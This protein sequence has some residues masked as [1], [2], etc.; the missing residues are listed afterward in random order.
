MRLYLDE[1]S[2]SS[3]LA[4]L[5]RAAGHDIVTCPELGSEGASDVVQFSQSNRDQRAILTK[6]HH[7]FEDLHDL[8]QA[9]AGTHAGVLVVLNENKKRRDM[10][11]QQIVQAVNRLIESSVPIEN[12]INILNH[13]RANWIFSQL[14]SVTN[15]NT[16]PTASFSPMA[17][18]G[19]QFF[20]YP[21]GYSRWT[22]LSMQL[23]SKNRSSESAKGCEERP[24]GSIPSGHYVCE[25]GDSR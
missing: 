17:E 25:E 6:N 24:F 20:D 5:L 8:V 1:D 18:K 4:A 10:T 13:F 7:D 3:L 21:C 14:K 19:Y 9:V 15:G 22:I 16:F 2:S 12:E 23:G 11:E